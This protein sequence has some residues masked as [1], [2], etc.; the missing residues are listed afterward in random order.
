MPRKNAPAC[1]G[2]GAVGA[3]C[4]SNNS[5]M[6]YACDEG[7]HE[8][9]DSDGILSC[10]ENVCTCLNGI[11]G[12]GTQCPTHNTAMCASC[13]NGYHNQCVEF[14]TAETVPNCCHM[15]TGQD[16]APF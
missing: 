12:T 6:C 5:A 2:V 8:Q 1:N 9:I 10:E 4:P 14:G 3:A 11:G 16:T 15:P 13:E 7:Y